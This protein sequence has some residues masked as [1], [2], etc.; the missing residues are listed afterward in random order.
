MNNRRKHNR[1]PATI[2]ILIK[3][4]AIGEK[5]IK[6]KDISDGGLF[7]LVEPEVMPSIGEIVIGQVQ[8]IP[9]APLVDMEIVRVELDGIGLRYLCNNEFT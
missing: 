9:D 3:H 2:D 1:T 6:T 7:I 5:H 4:N 8:G